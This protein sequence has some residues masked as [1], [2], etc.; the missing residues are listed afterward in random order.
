MQEL[1]IKII[2]NHFVRLFVFFVVVSL[3]IKQAARI[4]RRADFKSSKVKT[5][6]KNKQNLINF[7]NRLKI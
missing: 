3:N 5:K 6:I 7:P 2:L 4:T 1:T